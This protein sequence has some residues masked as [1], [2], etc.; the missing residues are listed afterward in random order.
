MSEN[1]HLTK[2]ERER[3]IQWLRAEAALNKLIA[4]QMAKM[5]GLE[6]LAKRKRT[7]AM[8]AE[9]VARVPESIEDETIGW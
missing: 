5:P 9:V 4:E 6:A 7:E 3:F 8:A 2:E 1:L